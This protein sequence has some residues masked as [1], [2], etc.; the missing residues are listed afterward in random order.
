M[1]F[2]GFLCLC[3]CLGYI[4]SKKLPPYMK[5]CSRNDPKLNE[6]ALKHGREAIPFLL[7]G[8]PKYKIPNFDP[9]LI[10]RFE[11]NDQS[12]KAVG[13]S[14][15]CNKCTISGLKDVTLDDMRIDLKKKKIEADLTAKKIE[16]TGKYNVTGKVLVLPINGNGDVDLTVTDVKLTMD[17]DYELYKKKDKDHLKIKNMKLITEPSGSHIKLTNLFNGDKMLGDNMNNFLNENWKE[18]DKTFGPTINE[19]ISRIGTNL[20][21]SLSDQVPFDEI[22]TK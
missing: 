4:E 17:I 18:L 20:I 11:V 12:N 6:C 22:F 14:F 9:L 13:L 7:K 21:N 5:P 16:I 15:V 19:V 8:D 10:E 3:A 2:W 1:K